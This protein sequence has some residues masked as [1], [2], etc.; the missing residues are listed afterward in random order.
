[1][2]KGVLATMAAVMVVSGCAT[3][4][5]SRVNPLNWFGRS[6]AAAPVA[7][8]S[9]AKV[10]D[11]LQIAEITELSLEQTNAGAI[12]KVTGLPPT[13]GWYKAQLVLEPI[14]TEGELVYRFYLEK[15]AEAERVG[16]PHSRKITAALFLN[17][18]RLAE[19][20]TIT[21]TGMTNSRSIRRR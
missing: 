8:Q 2:R 21:V 7:G 14:Q 9:G 16:T 1:M 11:R 15:P 13:Q 4:R 18:F 17:E 12:L 5:E 20:S 3:V 19:I 6:E 10:D